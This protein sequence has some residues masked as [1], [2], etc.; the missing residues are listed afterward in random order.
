MKKSNYLNSKTITAYRILSKNYAKWTRISFEAI[1]V[2]TTG[3]CSTSCLD[4]ENELKSIGVNP[5]KRK[6]NSS[7]NETVTQYKLKGVFK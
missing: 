2:S 1:A 3:Y 6:Y 4:L 5:L 7:T